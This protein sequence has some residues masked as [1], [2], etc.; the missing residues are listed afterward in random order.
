MRALVALAAC[1]SSGAPGPSFTQGTTPRQAPPSNVVGGFTAQLPPVTLQPGDEQ[2]PCFI[3]PLDVQGPSHLVGGAQVI[4]QAGMH[5]GNVTSRPSTGTG[6]RPCPDGDPNNALG[7]SGT[8]VAN[9]G[10]VLFASSTQH[11]GSE[12][13]SMPDGMA[14]PVKDGFEIVARM[15]YLNASPQPLTVA[16]SYQWYTVDESAV[17]T[18]LAPFIWVYSGFQIPPGAT[19]T[20]EGDC[21]FPPGMKIVTV[22]PH[23]HALGTRFT[24]GFLGGALDGQL[25]LDSKGYDPT[26]GV[27]QNLRSAHRSLAGRRIELRVHVGQHHRPDHRRGHGHQRD[28]HDVRVRLP[29]GDDLHRGGRGAAAQVRLRGRARAVS[30]VDDGSAPRAARWRSTPRASTGPAATPS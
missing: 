14:F 18:V 21:N 30:R 12:W 6:I 23:M 29:R 19:Y 15:H 7:G 4:A 8:D 26:N 11:V 5:H 27:M 9:G 20:V 24:A 2:Y 22:L 17:T 3:F 1:S 25:W 10:T 28:V 13:L 16:P